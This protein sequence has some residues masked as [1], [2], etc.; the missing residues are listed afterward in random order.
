MEEHHQFVKHRLLVQQA[1]VP[2][3]NQH[4]AVVYRH[5]VALHQPVAVVLLLTATAYHRTVVPYRRGVAVHR[6][7]AVVRHHA[8]TVTND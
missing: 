3:A 7:T 8:A 5:V 1:A 4:L 6:L 2:A